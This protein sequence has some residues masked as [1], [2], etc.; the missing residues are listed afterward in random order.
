MPVIID[1]DEKLQRVIVTVPGGTRWASFEEATL[2]IIAIE[3]KMT[4]W[5]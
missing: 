5:T 4:E 1:T 3:P 2:A